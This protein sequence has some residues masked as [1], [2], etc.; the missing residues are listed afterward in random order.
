MSEWIAL[1]C[2]G[3]KL[4]IILA[5]CC[6]RNPK[7]TDTVITAK[8]MREVARINNKMTTPSPPNFRIALP[9]VQQA[10]Q[11]PPTAFLGYNFP[12]DLANHL[13]AQ[14]WWSAIGISF[15]IE[16]FVSLADMPT[17]TFIGQ[18]DGFTSDSSEVVLDAIRSV[19]NED[20][21]CFDLME[22][23][24]DDLDMDNDLQIVA[25]IADLLQCLNAEKLDRKA[26]GGLDTPVFNIFLRWHPFTTLKAWIKCRNVIL[27]QTYPT[28]LFGTGTLATPLSCTICTCATCG[29]CHLPSIA[30]WNGPNSDSFTL[31][32]LN[33]EPNT[34]DYYNTIA[35]FIPM[36]AGRGSYRARRRGGAQGSHGGGTQGR[37]P[38]RKH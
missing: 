29:L 28:A 30:G 5:N 35:T 32:H 34:G 24:S 2:T 36:V 8:L 20:P 17:P 37:G 4:I 16:P 6:D 12:D 15:Y 23:I 10:D 26:H 38:E 18:T 14:G 3:Q 22:I 9:T 27:H 19:L 11:P 33:L 31:M 7:L 1:Q 25:V 13:L 21:A